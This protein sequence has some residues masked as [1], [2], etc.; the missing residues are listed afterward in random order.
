MRFRESD[1]VERAAPQIFKRPM[2]SVSRGDPLVYAASF[3]ALGPQIYVDGLVV[4]ENDKVV[5]RLG[6]HYLLHHILQSAP[7]WLNGTVSDIKEIDS[8]FVEARSQLKDALDIFEKTRFAFLPV[9]VDGAPAGSLSLRD[10]LGAIAESNFKAPASRLGSP[11]VA[12]NS[13]AS[14][15]DVL[16]AMMSK[17]IRNIGIRRR[18]GQVGIINDRKV[19]EFLLSHEGRRLTK[20]G[21]KLDAL[22][23]IP[24]RTLSLLKP[25][26][27]AKGASISKAASLLN[28]VDNPCL[29]SDGLIVTPW[30]LV[31]KGTRSA[32]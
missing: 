26:T 29:L 16:T 8:S 30:D 32:K 28:S 4:T 20:G 21:D 24:A 9:T 17:W 15:L 25:K 18:G 11:L 1:T 22:R 12:L 23:D 10:L 31:M 6:N 5:G 19:L 13:E 14:L 3:L 7:E 27:V 2:L